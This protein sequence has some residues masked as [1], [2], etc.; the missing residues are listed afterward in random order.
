MLIE[1]LKRFK[2]EVSLKLE[3]R[4]FVSQFVSGGVDCSKI[5]W[6]KGPAVS[7]V[8]YELEMAGVTPSKILLKEPSVKKNTYKHCYDEGRLQ[9]VD[10]YNS[11][12]EVH[13]VEY[14]IYDGSRVYSLKVNRH[15]EKLW[16][17][18]IELE[19]ELVV[20][21]C[22]VDFDLEFWSFGY[23]WNGAQLQE[24]LTFSSNSIPGVKVYPAYGENEEL[25]AL[26]FL[27]NEEKVYVYEGQ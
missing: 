25:I 2:D 27:N 10:V 21:A 26:Y 13:E 9:R 6:S 22:R 12:G 19:Q 17:K 14:F 18:A 5:T 8:P 1:D 4:F 16:L 11:K 23:E 7:L 20:R 24:I 3:D 15:G